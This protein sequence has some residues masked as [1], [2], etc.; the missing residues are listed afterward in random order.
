MPCRNELLLHVYMLVVATTR[1]LVTM[2]EKKKH[3]M[4]DISH[5]SNGRLVTIIWGETCCSK[6]V[7]VF[8]LRPHSWLC[9]REY[10]IVIYSTSA[11]VDS[12]CFECLHGP[13]PLHREQHSV[14]SWLLEEGSASQ[15]ESRTS[16][17]KTSHRRWPGEGQPPQGFGAVKR[18]RVVWEMWGV[19][20]NGQLW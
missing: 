19:E 16:E 12:C 15:S 7:W 4:G 9:P 8:R 2:R 3:H 5:S 18:Y 17:G 10:D 20:G 13:L 14:V 6:L 11:F 1:V